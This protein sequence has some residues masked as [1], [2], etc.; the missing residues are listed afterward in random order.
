[1]GLD[2]DTV[3]FKDKSF[4]DLLEDVYDNATLK[5]SQID[6]LIQ[7]LKPFMKNIGDAVVIVPLIKEY[8]EVAVK[9]DE[10][11]VKVVAVL[12]RL[13]SSGMRGV[14]DDSVLSEAEKEQLLNELEDASESLQTRLDDTDKIAK[15]VTAIG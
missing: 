6:I 13:I 9:N 3:F 1:M 4:S 8:M 7:E 12:Q 15:T 10:H 14:E 2:K 11:I 5:R